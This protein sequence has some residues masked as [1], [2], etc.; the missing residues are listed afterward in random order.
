M[1][2]GI[3]ILMATHDPAVAAVAQQTLKMRYGLRV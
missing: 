2:L 3:A 1:S